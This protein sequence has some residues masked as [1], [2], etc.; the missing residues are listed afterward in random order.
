MSEFQLPLRER[1][2]GQRSEVGK[3]H[4][5]VS[6]PLFCFVWG[7]GCSETLICTKTNLA[8]DHCATIYLFASRGCRELYK[9]SHCDSNLRI[10]TEQRSRVLTDLQ[11]SW[12][13]RSKQTAFCNTRRSVDIFGWHESR[14]FTFHCKIH[15]IRMSVFLFHPFKRP[16]CPAQ[17]A[18]YQRCNN[19]TLP[20]V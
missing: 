17:L 10:N 6:K 1:E 5:T 18:L 15:I 20:Y 14:V 8:G 11:D 2:R 16:S 4:N 3:V 13:R 7:G 19:E 12:R 9:I